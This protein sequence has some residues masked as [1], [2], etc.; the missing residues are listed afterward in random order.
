MNQGPPSWAPG[1]DPGSMTLNDTDQTASVSG[2]LTPSD[3]TTAQWVGTADANL[4]IAA[5]R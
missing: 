4:K 5:T 3:Q 1:G 2:V